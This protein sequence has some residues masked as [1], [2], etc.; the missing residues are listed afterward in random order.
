MRAIWTCGIKRQGDGKS[1]LGVSSEGGVPYGFR[2]VKSG[3]LK[4]YFEKTASEFQGAG[5]PLPTR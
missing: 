2:C 5:V 4:I 1:R 3:T